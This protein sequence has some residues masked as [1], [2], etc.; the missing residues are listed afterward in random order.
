MKKALSVLLLITLASMVFLV[1]GCGTK[2]DYESPYDVYSAFS[3]NEDI[4]GKTVEVQVNCD[5]KD[6]AI[7]D[8]VTPD[9]STSIT[10]YVGEEATKKVKKGD[11]VIVR[12]SRHE[13]KLATFDVYGHIV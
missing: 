4:D 2:A 6:D 3:K 5:Y 10:V 8:G 9:F 12:I 11:T 7:Y 1:S 13:T